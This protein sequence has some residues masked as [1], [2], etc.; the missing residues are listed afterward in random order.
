[1]T[2]T[3]STQITGS[4]GVTGSFSVSG[5]GY[6]VLDAT[7]FTGPVTASIISASSGITGSLF[8][9]AS[10]AFN[11]VT[12]SYVTGSIFTST[13]QALSASYALTASFALNG[14]GG[15]LTTKAGS[16]ANSS[17]TGNPKKA[18]VTFSTAFSNTNYAITVTGED[19]RT[20][21]IESKV[22]GSFVINANANTA[23][24]GTTY[25]IAT[26]YGETT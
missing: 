19:S 6:N 18:T 24:A 15:G 23:L 26:A 25:W 10:W 7:L 3:G 22:A 21:T 4:L 12:A 1:L 14:G 20:W 16:V 9:T 5:S 11:A 8:G 17:F 13:N 2:V